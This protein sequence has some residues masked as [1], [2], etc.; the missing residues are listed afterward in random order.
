MIVV[1]DESIE[2]AR[3]AFS[4]F[5]SVTQMPGRAIDRAAVRDADLL[6]VRSRTKINAALLDGSRV[7]FVGSG[8]IGLDHVDLEYLK[9]RGIAFAMRQD[10]APT[11]CRN[12]S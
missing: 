6:F 11:R 1:A 5:G 10:A 12:T 4:Q 3:E 2:Y 9:Q 7:R 8:I